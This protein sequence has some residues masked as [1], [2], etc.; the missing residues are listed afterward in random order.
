[1]V[2]GV[3]VE[4]QEQNH[5]VPQENVRYEL[6]LM[7]YK[8]PL[9][10]LEALPSHSGLPLLFSGGEDASRMSLQ[11]KITK[12]VQSE[13]SG[14]GTVIETSNHGMTP[15]RPEVI[16]IDEPIAVPT[17]PQLTER[18]AMSLGEML[19]LYKSIGE[20]GEE[21]EVNR[22]SIAA[23]VPFTPATLDEPTLVRLRDL[24]ELVVSE[25]FAD[26]RQLLLSDAM[27]ELLGYPT[28]EELEKGGYVSTSDPRWRPPHLARTQ[29]EEEEEEGEEEEVAEDISLEV[30]ALDCE[31]VRTE[32]GLELAR[33]TVVSPSSPGGVALDILVK[34]EK[35]VID[36]CTEFSGITEPLL[37]Q[38]TTTKADAL[39]QLRR[40]LSSSTIL[41]GHS[42]DSDLRCLK[43]FHKNVIDTTA[44]F[45]HPKGAPFKHGLKKLA[46]DYLGL[47]I[48]ENADHDSCQD[49]VISLELALLKAK[50]GAGSDFG[51]PGPWSAGGSIP[52]HPLLDEALFGLAASASGDND[53]DETPELNGHE[54]IVAPLLTG[55]CVVHSCPPLASNLPWERQTMGFRPESDAT[56]AIRSAPDTPATSIKPVCGVH[57]VAREAFEAALRDAQERPAFLW[58]DLPLALPPSQ[59]ISSSRLPQGAPDG[60]D[61]TVWSDL[62]EVD[63]AIAE[64]FANMAPD[65]LLVVV[66]QGDIALLKAAVSRKQRVIW[67]ERRDNAG[68]APIGPWTDADEEDMLKRCVSVL[69][70]AAFL[71]L[72]T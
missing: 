47:N 2:G 50:S 69:C 23:A 25:R 40:L 9:D 45:P 1:M 42:L 70:G 57:R 4:K 32:I 48:R 52:R 59:D 7:W 41:V 31:M 61:G 65:G 27:K 35:S 6:C 36:Y 21:K 58:L 39:M 44:L 24:F 3:D 26:F 60:K 63:N 13:K 17:E 11:L 66:S 71:K 54:S 64:L 72:K 5:L 37:R 29:L 55:R 15:A 19:R 38:I 16:D 67:E 34:P 18:E 12:A 53:T 49:A 68:G 22:E 46:A 43:I 14:G 28:G 56:W 8:R 33:L 10:V 51:M 30:C 20:E 62:R